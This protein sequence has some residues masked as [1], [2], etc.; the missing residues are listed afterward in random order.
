MKNKCY[1]LKYGNLSGFEISFRG[2]GVHMRSTTSQNPKF[3]RNWS[4]KGLLKIVMVSSL[5]H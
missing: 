4:I 5:D 2:F 1:V 3:N